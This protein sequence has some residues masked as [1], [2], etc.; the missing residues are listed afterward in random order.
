MNT[1]R[2]KKS[3]AGPGGHFTIVLAIINSHLETVF[4]AI[5]GLLAPGPVVEMEH[6]L[7]YK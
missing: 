2:A 7:G 5:G 3:P 1:S 6:E 4:Q